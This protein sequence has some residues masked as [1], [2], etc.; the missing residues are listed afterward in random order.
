[1]RGSIRKRGDIWYYRYRENDKLI[2][3]RGGS[4]E[5]AEKKL[6]DVLYRINNGYIS[7]SD[8]LLKDYMLMWVDD[9]IKD[10]KSEN[11]YNKYVQTMEK[12]INPMIGSIKLSDIKVMH[13]EK[14]IRDLK[15]VK[16]NTNKLISPTSVQS[17]YGILRSALNKAVK[18]QL[19]NNSPCRF[20]DTPRRAKFKANVLT[21]EELRLI[22]KK[23][24]SDSYEDYIFRLALD[25][26][27][28]TGLRRGELC[29]LDIDKD[30][31]IEKQTLT[32]QQALIRVKNTYVLSSKLK[33]ESSYRT[34]PI[35]NS[36]CNKIENHKKTLKMNK[37]KY[38]EFYIKNKFNN[39]YPNLLLVQENGKFMIPSSLLQR[40]KRLMK[41]CNVEKNIRWHDLRH[42]NATL[43]LEGGVSMKVLQER[44][45]H[46]LMQTTSDIYAHVTD[47]LNREATQTISNILNITK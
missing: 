45:G 6:N 3:K 11:T 23:V 27:S 31:N 38:G 10:E 35:S 36:L 15:K 24:N 33:T 22:Y 7:D 5:E 19:I 41:Y 4:K 39:E 20:V 2:E 1:M 14:F 47:N 30:I 46:S 32:I 37:L 9:Y 42:T 17:Y 43:L 26:T 40:I 29:G 8:M 12:Y 28:E 25:I 18:L 44:L 21:I 34:L 16:V 13:I